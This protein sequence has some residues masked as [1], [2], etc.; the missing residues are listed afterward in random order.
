MN[1]DRVAI[2]I[3]N[4]N[5]FHNL[6][7]LRK[8]D[9][10]WVCLYDP[11]WLAQRLAGNRKIVYIGFYCT[12][13][14]SYLLDDGGYNEERHKK[15]MQYYS[16]I[17]KLPG[18]SIKFGYLKGHKGDL[19]EKNLDTQIA[20]DLISMAALNHYDVAIIVSNDGDYVSAAE[21]ARTNFKKRIESGFFKGNSSMNL[22]KVCD[23]SRRL[24]RSYF[25][26]LT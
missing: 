16:A 10:N 19:Q 2:F 20:T 23:L 22:R 5:I 1:Q 4:S 8:I 7:D 24:R 6:Y 21:N 26:K 17:E 12:R 15:T 14:P 3:D 25:K 9:L 11:I 18:V 13:P